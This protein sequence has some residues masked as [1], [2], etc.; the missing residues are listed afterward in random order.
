MLTYFEKRLYQ[1]ANAFM[2]A[3]PYGLVQIMSSYNFTP[4]DS[5]QG[6]QIMTKHAL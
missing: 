6:I 5:D 1:V 4:G 3:W 2:L